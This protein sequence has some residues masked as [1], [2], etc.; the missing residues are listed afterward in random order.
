[1]GGG[2]AGD[3]TRR[4]G[5]GRARGVVSAGLRGEGGAGGPP[6]GGGTAGGGP[7]RHRQAGPRPRRSG[8]PAD[9][10][11][12][13]GLT[14]RVQQARALRFGEVGRPIVRPLVNNKARE[15]LPSVWLTLRL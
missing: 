3:T 12:G 14:P 6:G 15:R 7:R 9:V 11:M 2:G 10:V 8:R 5:K 13:A 4:K 1:G